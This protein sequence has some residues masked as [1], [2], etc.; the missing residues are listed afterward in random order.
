ATALQARTSAEASL[1]SAEAR[2]RDADEAAASAGSDFD[3]ALATSGF[4]G[5]DALDVARR[6]AGAIEALEAALRRFDA[7][8]AAAKIRAER[9]AAAAGGREK[10][11]LA[12]CQQSAA[13][14]RAAL[15]RN[16]D[17]NGRLGE[18]LASIRRSV[19]ALGEIAAIVEAAERRFLSVGRVAAIADGRNEAG[20]SL[21]R[22]ALGSLLD[23]VLA[24]ATERLAR[25]SQNRFALVRAGDRRDRRRSGGLD[26]EVFDSHTGVA[27][28]AATLSGGESFL[29]SL[30]LALGLADI[31]HAHAGGIR[32]DTMF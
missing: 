12:A 27:R 2:V 11:D 18:A 29:A 14:A 9:A 5:R 24:A 1:R 4:A 19:N 23:D 17:E 8:L 25:M 10:P 32:L 16:L 7:T 3:S 21:A 28:P 30:S 20:I 15:D 31:V 26:L 22:F 6:A 13:A